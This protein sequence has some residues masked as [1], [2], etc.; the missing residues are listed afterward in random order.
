LLSFSFSSICTFFIDK[1]NITSKTIETPIGITE[2]RRAK[3]QPKQ[4]KRF[5]KIIFLIKKTKMKKV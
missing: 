5:Y 3:I 4:E 2:N 1:P